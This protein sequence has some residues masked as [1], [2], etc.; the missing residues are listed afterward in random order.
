VVEPGAIKL[1][2]GSSSADLR[3]HGSFDIAGEVTDV[4]AHKA[5]F[6]TVAIQYE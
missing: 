6:S 5:Y 4:G 3:L 1:M 2:I